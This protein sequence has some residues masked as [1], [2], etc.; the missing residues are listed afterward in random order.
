MADNSGADSGCDDT[1]AAD[2]AVSTDETVAA[3]L[4]VA[5]ACGWLE[6]CA[7]EPALNLLDRELAMLW[8]L[9]N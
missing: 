7:V 2:A 8:R 5:A 1:M 9:T 3:A 4:D 6:G